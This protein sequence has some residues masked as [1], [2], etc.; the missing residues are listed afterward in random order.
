MF[1]VIALSPET[2]RG[3]LVFNSELTL[4]SL[5]AAVV[6]HAWAVQ[7]YQHYIYYPDANYL[8]TQP[9]SHGFSVVCI[10]HVFASAPHPYC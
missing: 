4:R 3:L 5:N 6:V 7:A 1:S 2:L 10:S 9:S 8:L